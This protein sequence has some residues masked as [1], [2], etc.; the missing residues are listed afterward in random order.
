MPCTRFGSRQPSDIAS[1]P[2]RPFFRCNCQQPCTVSFYQPEERNDVAVK[3]SN[4]YY[5]SVHLDT[6]LV[7]RSVSDLG[8]DPV[9]GAP[10]RFADD[11][12]LMDDITLVEL[13]QGTC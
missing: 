1:S 5:E 12:N 7:R 11:S 4:N 8:D 3:I 13:G 9:S 6:K 2:Q 10:Y